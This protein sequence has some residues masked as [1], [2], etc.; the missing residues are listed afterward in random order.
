[1]YENNRS[2]RE[3]GRESEAI[4]GN[5]RKDEEEEEEARLQAEEGNGRVEGKRE[6]ARKDEIKTR[7][8]RKR[9]RTR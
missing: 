2:E 5:T 4:G 1:M 9:K 6:K 8:I 7:S 3:E